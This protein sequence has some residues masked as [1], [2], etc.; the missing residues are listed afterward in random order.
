MSKPS[1]LPTRQLRD[2][3]DLDQL[4]RQAKELL[5]AFC[6]GDTDAVTEVS[7]FYRD[8]DP[9]TFK[10][11][12]AQL[13]LARAHGFES[14]PDLVLEV[15]RREP[16]VRAFV[17]AVNAGRVDDVRGLLERDPDLKARIDHPWF[18]F[19][20]TALLSAVDHDNRDLVNLLLDWGAD[21]NGESDWEM[22]GFTPLHLASPKMG[23][24]LMTRGA[25]PDACGAAR[26]GDLDELE[27]IIATDPGRVHERGG[28]GKQ[29]LHMA[30]T[31]KCAE[32]LLDQ[33]ADLEG[34][35]A[36]HHSTPLMYHAV[37]HPEVARLLIQHG[38]RPDVFAAV[39]L[40]DLELLTR[41]VDERPE[42]A[43]ATLDQGELATPGD[44]CLIYTWTMGMG[45]GGSR[46]QTVLHGAA[47][48]NRTR[49][50]KLLAERGA[51]SNTPGGYDDATPLHAAAWRGHV[52]AVRVLV[53]AGAHVDRESGPTHHN[54]PCGWA[55]VA[56]HPKVVETLLAL[57]AEIR[58]YFLSD[59]EQGK[60]GNGV[61]FAPGTPEDFAQIE[62]LL[63]TVAKER[64]MRF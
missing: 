28:D 33:G 14:F 49:A 32:Y 15:E 57:G 10:L 25:V 27:R 37:D 30:T 61:P 16:E 62:Q 39:A 50:L 51:D 63:R 8:A 40:D 38:A 3:P 47:W 12:N 4:K 43:N 31:V 59:A 2:E 53:E 46:K 7:R 35:C 45:A 52:E 1:V 22:G 26:I 36:D 5:R 64:G 17:A 6:A 42:R 34:R 58:D 54:T 13:V 44:L 55:V 9:G 48:L 60:N 21:P 24:H 29:P 19:G 20:A 41:L 56:G 23:R 11:A 18:E